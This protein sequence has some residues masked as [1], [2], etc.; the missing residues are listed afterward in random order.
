MLRGC[1]GSRGVHKLHASAGEYNLRLGIM[2]EVRP[3]MVATHQSEPGCAAC[4]V[5]CLLLPAFHQL[6]I[7]A[8]SDILA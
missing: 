3:D 4:T 5:L 7:D 6:S 8:S 1:P 2:K